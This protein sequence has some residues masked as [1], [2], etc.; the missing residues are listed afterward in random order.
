MGRDSE[1][2]FN[3]ALGFSTTRSASRSSS[4]A[5]RPHLFNALSPLQA[6]SPLQPIAQPISGSTSPLPPS[7]DPSGSPGSSVGAPSLSRSS[8]VTRSLSRRQSL[9]AHA[10]RW[11]KGEYVDENL[12]NPMALFSRLT[13]VKAPQ[14]K[15]GIRR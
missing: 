11:D 1:D 15:Q 3:S 14:E 7:K 10:A 8:S 13:L 9:I 12:T 6:F 2:Y 4:S 5:T